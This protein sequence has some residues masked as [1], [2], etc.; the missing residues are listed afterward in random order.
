MSKFYAAV[1]YNIAANIEIVQ[2]N[3]RSIDAIESH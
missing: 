3:S 2:T 1:V